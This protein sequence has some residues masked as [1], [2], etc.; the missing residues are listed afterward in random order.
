M[1]APEPISTK[2]LLMSMLYGGIVAG[3]LYYAVDMTEGMLLG[4]MIPAGAPTAA[5]AGAVGVYVGPKLTGL[6]PAY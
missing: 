3:V 1:S 2:Q 6:L 5:I 4:N